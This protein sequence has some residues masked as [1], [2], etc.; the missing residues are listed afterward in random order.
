TLFGRPCVAWR[1]TTGR[2]VVMD[3]HCAHLGANLADGQIKDGCIQCPFHHWRY[4]EQGQCVH[5][6][7]HSEAVSRLEQEDTLFLCTEGVLRA[8]NAAREPFGEER[9]AAVLHQ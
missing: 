4:D 5:I 8:V 6:P 9:L 1:G 7:G 3:R 2:A